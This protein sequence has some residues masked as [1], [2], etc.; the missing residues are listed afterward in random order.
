MPLLPPSFPRRINGWLAMFWLLAAFLCPE[1]VATAQAVDTNAAA[2]LKAAFLPRLADFTTWPNK[3]DGTIV[4]GVTGSSG[5]ISK[6]LDL[7]VAAG[8]SAQGC[9]I[10]VR[11]ISSPGDVRGVHLL[12]IGDRTGDDILRATSGQPVLTVS[13]NSGFSR[14]GGMVEFG[15][16][17][18]SIIFYINI[19]NVKSSGLSISSKLLG[20]KSV[21][22]VK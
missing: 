22:I 7:V 8:A 14:G 16:E 4:I 5:I 20:L 11:R 9:P 18:G 10:E 17:D 1:V 19:N 2:A 3:K 12:F 21:R 6:N 15:I 13:D